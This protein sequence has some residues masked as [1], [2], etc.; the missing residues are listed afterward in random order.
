[1]ANS[2][3]WYESA[4]LDAPQLNS[5]QPCPR[6]V[7][8]DYKIMDPAT[9]TLIPGCCRGV[10]P[11]E[12]GNGRRIF[13]AKSK[14]QPECVRL[15]GMAGFY[16][17]RRLKMSWSQWCEQKG[18]PFT[19]ALPG[20]PFV[21]VVRV[22]IGKGRP[23]G[24]GAPSGKATGRQAMETKIGMRTR[25]V[26]AEGAI[27]CQDLETSL[28]E[29]LALA[30]PSGGGG[31]SPVLKPAE[32]AEAS[33]AAAAVVPPPSLN[34]AAL[35][36]EQNGCCG[37]GACMPRLAEQPSPGLCMPPT[38]LQSAKDVEYEEQD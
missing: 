3:N 19:P 11:G 7:H 22:A 32:L 18:I 31:G 13:A 38:T 26:A 27:S 15:T 25:G 36:R 30:L 5:P 23:S 12:E 14:E 34:L 33:N 9:K 21:P 10:H 4:A 17:R 20:K 1:M 37:G 24:K 8:C 2:I 35:V 29:A 6:G 16:E 28:R